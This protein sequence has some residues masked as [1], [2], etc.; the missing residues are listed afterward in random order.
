[1]E[2][3]KLNLET[4]ENCEITRLTGGNGF[5][6]P[7]VISPAADK[8]LKVFFEKNKSLIEEELHQN[9]AILFRGWNVTTAEDFYTVMHSLSEETLK[10]TQR[11]SPR[12]EVTNKVYTSTD[13]PS[14]QEI[15]PHNESSYAST[16]PLLIAFFCFIEPSE[17][18]ETPIT[19]N[20]E[21]LKKLQESTI[22]TFREKGISY[23]RNML[24]WL[25]LSWEEVYQTENKSEVEDLLNKEKMNFE[26]I[27]DGHLRVKW[28]RPAFQKHPILD[29]EVW[30]NH[31]F[32]YHLLNQNPGLISLVE[33]EDLPFRATLG[34][35]TE[36]NEEIFKELQQAYKSATIT[37]PWQKG[38]VL[39]LDN[40]LFSHAR[41]PF[42]GER[43]ILVSMAKP[44]HY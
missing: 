28:D 43:K 37:F 41:N 14:D 17:G 6:M 34:D 8:D 35:G 36:I 30:F 33:K 22:N 23:T 19:N 26:W 21:M 2:T 42:K 13:Y 39:L 15:K 29:R 32:F 12:S 3:T 44:V 24:N 10:Y 9:G 4:I 11:T 27:D 7:R 18:G 38:D 40:M 1:M 25:G 31:S 20:M 5:Q 16:W